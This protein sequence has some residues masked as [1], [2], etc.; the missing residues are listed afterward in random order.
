[1]SEKRKLVALVY[2]DDDGEKLDI[3]RVVMLENPDQNWDEEKKVLELSD[4]TDSGVDEQSGTTQPP[5]VTFSKEED[6]AAVD[7]FCIIICN[8]VVCY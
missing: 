5:S 1:M 2:L 4:Y 8:V 7:R 3:E 6:S